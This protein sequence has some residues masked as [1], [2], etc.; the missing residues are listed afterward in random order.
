[1]SKFYRYIYERYGGYQIQKDNEHYGWYDDIRWA[2][3][4]RDRLEQV[5]WDLEE[6]VW[7]PE[8]PNPYLDIELPPEDLDRHRQYIYLNTKGF[9]IMKNIDGEVK[10]FGTYPTLDEAI[11]VRNELMR[12][13][14]VK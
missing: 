5:D 8:K 13:G 4:D 3:F 9:R 10:Y 7:L 1:M 2:L 6:F 12:N 11:K 14:W